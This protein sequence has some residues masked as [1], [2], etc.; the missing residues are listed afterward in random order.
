MQVDIMRLLLLLLAQ[1]LKLTMS[2][3]G[4][5]DTRMVGRPAP[6]GEQN[7]I[8]TVIA[9]H[10]HTV[11]RFLLAEE[12]TGLYIWSVK[13]IHSIPILCKVTTKNAHTQAN[14]HFF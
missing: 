12:M 9:Q 3:M 10:T 13:Q 7:L 11:R 1:D 5:S 14:E 6:I 2:W 4:I 8:A